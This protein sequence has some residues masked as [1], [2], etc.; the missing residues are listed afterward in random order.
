MERPS[1]GLL[2]DQGLWVV[3]AKSYYYY[4]TTPPHPPLAPPNNLANCII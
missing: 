2:N 3:Y 1:L 4:H